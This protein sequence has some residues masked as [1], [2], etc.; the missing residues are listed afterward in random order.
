M[1]SGESNTQINFRKLDHPS[2]LV[3][4]MHDDGLV[5]TNPVDE[6]SLPDNFILTRILCI[7]SYK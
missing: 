6:F 7:M 4:L 5:E 1:T 2:F 3:L